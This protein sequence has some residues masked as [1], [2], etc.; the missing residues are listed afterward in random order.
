M[1]RE[2]ELITVFRRL[3]SCLSCIYRGWCLYQRIIDGWY[4][5]T[6]QSLYTGPL[7]LSVDSKNPPL[8]E[9]KYGRDNAGYNL[10]TP[11]LNIGKILRTLVV[12]GT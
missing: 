11:T 8:P 4:N 7:L 1:T 6:C 10:S 12:Q 2:P 9:G 3:K 5:R